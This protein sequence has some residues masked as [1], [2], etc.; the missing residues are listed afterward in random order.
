MAP[1]KKQILGLARE[2]LRR[3]FDDQHSRPIEFDKLAKEDREAIIAA[4]S[5]CR[6]KLGAR[7][8]I[9]DCFRGILAARID[10]AEGLRGPH[11]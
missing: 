4:A 7:T 6:T 8:A 1:S 2:T 5:E 11:L 3:C 10:D 9:E